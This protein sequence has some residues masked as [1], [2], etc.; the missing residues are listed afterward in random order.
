MS[1]ATEYLKA[2]DFLLEH[3]SD[4]EFA[5]RNFRWPRLD[6]FNWALDY[7]DH[8]AA[9]NAR[10]AL[11]VLDENGGESILSFLGLSQRSNQVARFLRR[12][13][14]ARGDRVLLML[15]NEVPLWEAVLAAFKL[16]AVVIPASALLDTE[17]LRD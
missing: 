12:L 6:E 8:I 14:V 7:F 2:R 10:P 16:G 9:G 17:D 11:R 13:G 1:A 5:C 3:R 4:Q 15:G